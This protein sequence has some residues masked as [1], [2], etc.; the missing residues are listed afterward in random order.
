MRSV[1]RYNYH[2]ELD[3]AVQTIEGEFVCAEDTEYQDRLQGRLV[4][5]AKAKL[6]GI[7]YDLAYYDSCGVFLGLDKSRFLEEDELDVDDHLPIDVSVRIPDD[8]ASCVFN[9]R[10]KMPGKIGRLFWGG[11]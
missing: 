8:T 2:P 7:K 9:V 1:P 4:N 3:G 5:V 11:K 6:S 10:A